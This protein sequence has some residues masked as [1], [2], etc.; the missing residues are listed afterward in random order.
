MFFLFLFSVVTFESDDVR[1]EFENE[2]ADDISQTESEFERDRE[3]TSWIDFDYEGPTEGEIENTNRVFR[4]ILKASNP[5][6]FSN[7]AIEVTSIAETVV[8]IPDD[9]KE[10]AKDLDLDYFDENILEWDSV[11]IVENPIGIKI[12]SY[13]KSSFLRNVFQIY[14]RS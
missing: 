7:E 8:T 14:H 4:S 3:L 12:L 5:N 6:G 1:M 9:L 11:T 13:L 2:L 10:F